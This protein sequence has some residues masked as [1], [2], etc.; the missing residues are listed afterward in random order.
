MLKKL[1]KGIT[2]IEIVVSIGLI[3]IVTALLLPKIFEAKNKA[4]QEII[5]IYND[6]QKV[7]YIFDGHEITEEESKN[8]KLDD[9]KYKDGIIYKYFVL[10]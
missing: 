1:R 8:Y 6:N 4:E 2:L 7:V 5:D 9:V 3:A 10:K